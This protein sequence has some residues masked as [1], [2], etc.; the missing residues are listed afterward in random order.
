MG[1]S[2]TNCAKSTEDAAEFDNNNYNK[3]DNLISNNPKL[4]HC[5]V[6][7]QSHFRG[8][9]LRSKIQSKLDEIKEH[10]KTIE[11]QNITSQSIIL[12]DEELSALLN[13][14]PPLND[15][16]HVEIISPVEYPS[17]NII[18]YGEWDI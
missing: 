14:Y 18:Y 2:C 5:L 13:S 9:K 16:I 1:C 15:N 10:L 11:Q 4:L 6:K 3:I 12:S 8:R 17:N 7:I